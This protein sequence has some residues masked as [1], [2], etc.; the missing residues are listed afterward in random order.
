MNKPT[1]TELNQNLNEALLNNYVDGLIG[2]DRSFQVIEWNRIMELHY[3]ISRNDAISMD[4]FE[5]FPEL[6]R[7]KDIDILYEV[8][9][10]GN[11]YL[12]E[13]KYKLR[14]GYFEILITPIHDKEGN[15]TG[16]IITLHDI[17]EIKEM[18]EKLKRQ[19]QELANT[20]QLLQ[21]EIAEREKAEADLKKAHDNLERRVKE[22][23]A[24]LT[25]A[26]YEAENA[27]REKD[28]FLANMS[29]E[30]RTPMNAI[31]GMAQLLKDTPLTEHQTK[32]VNS[33]NF[34]S[35]TL[36][37]L[38]NDI[39]DFSKI[40]AGMIDFEDRTFSL[41]NLVNEVLEITSYRCQN[42]KV[43]LEK[44]VDSKVPTSVSGDK[45]RLN[46]ILLN[47]LSNAVKFTPHGKIELKI[48][49]EQESKDEIHLN[50]T[51][52]DT[53]I[54]IPGDKIDTIFEGF[55][56]A[57]SDTTRKYGGTGLGLTIVKSLVELQK[58]RV[59][60]KSQEDIGSEFS[61][62][63]PFKKVSTQDGAGR[64][65]GKEPLSDITNLKIL[66]VEDNE[67][68]QFLIQSLLVKYKAIVDV[69]PDGLAAL[70]ALK[71]NHYDLILMD[72]QMPNMDG[73]EAT[74]KIRSTF[75]EGKNKIPIVA[76]T[77]HALVG[78]KEKCIEAGMDDYITK[79][80]KVRELLNSIH[81]VLN[82]CL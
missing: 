24:E 67:L 45:Y 40:E 49:I 18:L 78:E 22:R 1:A 69:T 15:V 37:S 11:I 81:R 72:I 52:K 27:S 39:L 58:G 32:Y 64:N 66:V 36:L 44:Q 5:A 74:R 14:E 21:K 46:Q 62:T 25:K 77:A 42:S 57:S 35:D 26:K 16:G 80:I 65:K 54:G 51:V 43:Q 3:G 7:K 23:T 41:E 59:S 2:F 20:N 73:Y 82:Q 70:D 48:G 79:P 38:I 55:T 61:F 8:L 33:I 63:I 6:D 71:N 12:K 47:L 34:A 31:I 29:H 30:I 76:M 53:G 9:S 28:K 19:N 17:T 56:Q 10:G 60:V 4:I 50:F 68:N 13:K 75:D